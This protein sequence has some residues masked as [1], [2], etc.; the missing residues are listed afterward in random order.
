MDVAGAGDRHLQAERVG[1]RMMRQ[2]TQVQERGDGAD[3]VELELLEALG[4]GSEVEP[5]LL[6]LGL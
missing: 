6:D 2:E 3:R 1:I 4:V 5:G